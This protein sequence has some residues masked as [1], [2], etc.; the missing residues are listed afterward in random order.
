M[1]ALRR[2]Q[3]ETLVRSVYV[4]ISERGAPLSVAGYQGMV[5][6]TDRHSQRSFRRAPALLARP[7]R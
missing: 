4:F 1:R 6:S 7:M 3:R 2:L 5:V